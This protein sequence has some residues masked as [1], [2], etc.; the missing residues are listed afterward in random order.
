MTAIFSADRV[1]RYRLERGVMAAGVVAAVVMVN[2]SDANE[3]SNDATVRKLI[4]FG[5]RLGWRRFI[6]GNKFGL[7]SK[8]IKALRSAADPIGPDNDRHLEQI[9]R[10]ADV[11]IVAWGALAKLPETLR[12]RWCEVVRIADRVGCDLHCIGINDDGHPRHP[13]MTGYDV[14]VTR[15]RAP[16]FPNRSPAFRL[17]EI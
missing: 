2:G 5:Q 16:W 6:V 12:K 1:Y 11:H 15:W 7:V 14:P 10:D 3:D 8:D 9:L 17:K 13:V 4:G